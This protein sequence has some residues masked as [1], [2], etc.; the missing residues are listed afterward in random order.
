LKIV[1]TFDRAQTTREI[2]LVYSTLAESYKDNG[3]EKKEVVK[4]FASKKSGGTAP[5]TKI[6]TEESQVANRFQKL[7]GIMKS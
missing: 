2:K 1:E 7:A 4:E 3:G 5:K 6:I